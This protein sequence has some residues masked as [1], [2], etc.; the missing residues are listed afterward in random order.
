MMKYLI[1][2]KYDKWNEDNCFGAELCDNI[3]EVNNAIRR[4]KLYLYDDDEYQRNIKVY[5]A[6]EVTDEFDT[7]T[8]FDD[9]K[10]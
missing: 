7:K 4:I 9:E 5:K 6:E 8:K 3:G 10:D 1:T 2:Y